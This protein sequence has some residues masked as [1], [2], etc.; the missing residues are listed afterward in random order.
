MSPEFLGVLGIFV[1]IILFLLKIP[2]SISL[3][4]VSMI[5]TGLIRGFDIAL[6]QLGRTP[7]DTASS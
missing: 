5:G 4:I 3:I 2:V 1:L 6:A 7:F